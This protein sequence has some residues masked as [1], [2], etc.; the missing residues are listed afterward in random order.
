MI[1]P[2]A[3]NQPLD[4]HA[5]YSDPR[6]SRGQVHTIYGSEAQSPHGH[7]D[8]H[9]DYSDRL[10]QWD[11]QK[12]EEASF[13][14]TESGAARSSPRWLTVFLTYYYGRLVKL[15]HVLVGVNVSN[16]Y[17]YHVYGTR[18]IGKTS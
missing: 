17:A 10:W 18:D 7:P 4:L 12:A 5:H 13:V 15:E 14:A 6:F 9:Y 11:Y 2:V 8:L 3:S 1:Y 16:G